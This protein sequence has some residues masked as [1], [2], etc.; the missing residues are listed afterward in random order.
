MW[1]GPLGGSVREVK[2]Q[3]AVQP[4]APV[5]S[6]WGAA[7][8]VTW[9]KTDRRRGARWQQLLLDEPSLGLALIQVRELLTV[10]FA[11]NRGGLAVLFCKRR[12]QTPPP[13]LAPARRGWGMTGSV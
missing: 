6:K 5:G 12:E 1:G 8:G 13:C 3:Q 7:C 4:E 9:Q 2:H 11:I 10:I